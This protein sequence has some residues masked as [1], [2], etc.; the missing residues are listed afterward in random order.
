MPLCCS[1]RQATVSS[2]IVLIFISLVD[3]DGAARAMSSWRLGF[4]PSAPFACRD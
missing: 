4:E 1:S 2:F 3:V